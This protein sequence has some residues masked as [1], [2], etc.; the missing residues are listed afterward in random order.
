MIGLLIVVG[1]IVRGSRADSAE[2]KRPKAL[3]H[4]DGKRVRSQWS[5]INGP[6]PGN[7]ET[8]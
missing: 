8:K 5:V 7:G 6:R 4:T 2:G 1:E 3:R